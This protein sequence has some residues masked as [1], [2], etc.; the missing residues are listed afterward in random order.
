M[1]ESR[2]KKHLQHIILTYMLKHGLDQK[3]MAQRLEVS[4]MALSSWLNPNGHGISRK[5][6]EK[7]KFLCADVLPEIDQRN[8][9][10][11]FINSGDNTKISNNSNNNN[12]FYQEA[13]EKAINKYKIKLISALLTMDIE[14]ATLK[15]ILLVIDSLDA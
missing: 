1:S 4:S 12:F 2:E 15:Q 9:S 10:E 8:N 7:I 13:E 14:T 5:N 6:A 11:K 3:Q